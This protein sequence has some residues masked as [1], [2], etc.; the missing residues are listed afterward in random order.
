MSWFL[1]GLG[2]WRAAVCFYSIFLDPVSAMCGGR[3]FVVPVWSELPKAAVHEIAAGRGEWSSPL[4]PVHPGDYCGIVPPATIWD[5]IGPGGVSLGGSE[6]AELRARVTA[7]ARF[8]TQ[9]LRYSAR[10]WVFTVF[11]ET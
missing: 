7:A 1:P 5:G 11:S 2:R 3:A 9:S 8:S 6:Q 4:L 10:W